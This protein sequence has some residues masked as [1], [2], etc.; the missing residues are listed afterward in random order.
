M[1]VIYAIEDIND[2]IYVGSTKKKLY[3]RLSAHR[4]SKKSNTYRACSSKKLN[5]E[6][7]IIYELEICEEKDRNE[8]EQYWIDKLDCVNEKNTFFDNK[9]YQRKYQKERYNKNKE[10]INKSR[11]ESRDKNKEERNRKNREYKQKNKDVINKK[12][13]ERYH[14]KKQEKS[15]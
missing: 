3:Q 1:V 9:E 12:Q 7:C 4:T 13:R 2:L 14:K 5:L 6:Y 10:E 15:E 11:R 8:R